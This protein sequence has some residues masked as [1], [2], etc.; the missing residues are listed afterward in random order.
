MRQADKFLIGGRWVAPNTPNPM[1]VINPATEVA[2]GDVYLGSTADV[3]AAV[4]AAH[5]A[6]PSFSRSTREQRI[7][8][9]EEVLVHYDRRRGEL[10]EAITEEM[11][12]PRLLAEKL[13]AMIGKVHLKTA[14]K[15]LREY[16]FERRVGNTR[17]V[18]EPIGVCAFITPWNWPIN[19]IAVKVAPAL[20]CGCTMVLKP[21]ELS[22]FSATIWAEILNDAGVPA[23]VFNMVHG[24]GPEVG[25]ALVSHPLVAMVSFTGSQQAGINVARNAAESIKRVHQELG[26]K[27]AN[28]ILPDADIAPSV[29]AGVRAAM[30]NS[31]QSCN[32]PTRMLVPRDRLDEA[33]EA[34]KSE[35]EQLTVG[36]PLENPDLGPV[37]S[38]AQFDKIQ[39]L[40]QSGI[41]GGAK[42]IVGGPGRPHGLN[43]GFYVRPT[44]FAEVSNDTA[45]AREEIFG[46][47]LS[48]IAYDAIEDAV[49]IANDSPFGIAG[50][51]QGKNPATLSKVAEELRVGQVVINQAAPDPL[52]PF[53]GYKQSGNGREWG[54]YAFEAYLEIKA[55]LGSAAQD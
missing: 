34:A 17:V 9:L 35:A 7:E 22:P 18:H 24:T 6:F 54:E 36:N 39:S 8:L 21:S 25:A 10:T 47:V 30:A 45:I 4:E 2:A 5:R 55:I 13:H 31:G 51:V 12:A 32:A 23:G 1:P 52:A 50:Y 16:P 37:V 40:I 49:A 29:R 3:N 46:P 27:S 38:Q 19:Q 11:G 48:I 41:E 53:G 20:A 44:I 15:V 28:I 42:L 43:K 14:L 26:G 33:V